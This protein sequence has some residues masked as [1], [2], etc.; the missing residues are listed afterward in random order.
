M[1]ESDEVTNRHRKWSISHSI[2]IADIGVS[3][4]TTFVFTYSWDNDYR[5]ESYISC[6]CSCKSENK[7]NNMMYPQEHMLQL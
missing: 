6:S 7:L 5:Q 3:E 4:R 2:L 1:K